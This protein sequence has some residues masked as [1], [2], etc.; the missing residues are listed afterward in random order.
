MENSKPIPSLLGDRRR[1]VGRL[2]LRVIPGLLV[3][4]FILWGVATLPWAKAA[5]PNSN[6]DNP[7]LSSSSPQSPQKIDRKHL[8][9]LISE[10]KFEEAAKEAARL[11]EEAKSRGDEPGWAWALIKEVQL[12]IALHGYETSVRFLKE[13]PW[14]KSPIQRGMLDLFYAP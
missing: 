14:P 8:D 13:E 4:I 12:R 11:R 2:A 5:R 10:E 3:A 1:R 7:G 6:P 9:Q